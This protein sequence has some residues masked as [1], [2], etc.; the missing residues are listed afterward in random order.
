MLAMVFEVDSRSL[1]FTMQNHPAETPHARLR[2]SLPHLLLF[3]LLGSLL[4]LGEQRSGLYQRL[5]QEDGW[6]EWATFLAFAVAAYVG[7][8]SFFDRERDQLARAACLALGLFCVFVAGEEISWGQRL[9]GFRPPNYFLEQ[10]YQQEANLH[11][12]LKNILDT[13]F[14][15]LAIAL[16]Y[17]VLAP[18][19]ARVTRW[20]Q[21]LAAPFSLLPWFAAVAWIEY[22]YP[23]ELVGELA[24]LMLG[25]LF[26]ADLCLRAEHTQVERASI[27]AFR[28]Q[29]A[30]LVCAGLVV[31]LNDALL[32]W[33]SEAY[34]LVARE[35]LSTLRDRINEGE[36]VKPKLLN[37]KR[38]HKRMFTAVRAGYLDLSSERHFLDPW[39]SPYWIAY[40]RD[41]D[42]TGGTVI[43]YSFGP[44]RRRDFV[45]SE[46]EDA[47]LGNLE[48]A[49][50]PGDDIR[51]LVRV[52]PSVRAER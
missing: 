37:K 6:A 16:S 12:L 21:T 1:R 34:A 39:N 47:D 11:N 13:R 23:Y 50:A 20:P 15:V 43:L 7:I 8:R 42:K 46:A 40:R 25:L 41:P 3:A 29:A 18:F 10:N 14:V 5:L 9:L 35:D 27:R 17:G 2:R 48:S 52:P 31:P 51:V 28:A 33:N 19:L 36:L 45:I 49:A 32:R 4:C 44:N 26:L 38:V 24:E 22:S 30:A